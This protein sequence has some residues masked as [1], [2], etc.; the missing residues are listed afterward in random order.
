MFTFNVWIFYCTKNA[1]LTTVVSLTYIPLNI[2][3]K[4]AKGKAKREYLIPI[5]FN[6]VS[7]KITHDFY[8]PCFFG[9]I[10]VLLGVLARSGDDPFVKV[11][12][13]YRSVCSSMFFSI[14]FIDLPR[15]TSFSDSLPLS[16]SKGL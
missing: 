1:F 16:Y 10:C 8:L 7:S 9:L 14:F 13:S 6:E 4:I 3:G 5:H 12:P 2:I 11:S 15:V